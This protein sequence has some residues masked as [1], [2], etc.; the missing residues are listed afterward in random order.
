[1]MT[2]V[3]C[4]FNLDYDIYIRKSEAE[5]LALKAKIDAT[6]RFQGLKAFV[7]RVLKA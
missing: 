6:K 1:M 5:A 4:C 3:I 7:V 2:L